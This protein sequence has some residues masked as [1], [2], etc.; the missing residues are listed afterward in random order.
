MTDTTR[1]AP[2]PFRLRMG[3]RLITTA[4]TIVFA[5]AAFAQQDKPNVVLMLAD[6]VGWGDIGAFAGGEL[7]G[8]PTPAIDQLAAEG[9]QLSQ[10]LVEPACTPSRAA[11]LTGRYSTRVG[12]NTVII[13]G[14]PNT[15]QASEVTLAELFKSQGYATAYAGKWHLGLE[16]QS[17]P[18]RQGFD[19]YRVGVIETTDGTLY[20]ESMERSGMPE[21]F[22]KNVVPRIYESDPDGT[23]RAVREYTVEYRAQVEGDIAAASV[24]FIT[25]QADAGAPFFM[26][27]G[28]THSHYPSVVPDEFAGKSPAGPYGDAIMEL[29]YRTGQVLDA[30]EDAGVEDNTIVIWISDNGATPISGP[31]A[32]RGG[33]NG[34][35]RGELGD[36]LE[37]SI[38][39][40]GMIKWPNRIKPGNSFEM[41]SIHDMLP[42]LATIIGAKIPSDR[43]IDG[44]DQSDYFLGETSESNR[45]HLITFIE[46]EVAAVRW[47]HWR[48]YPKEFV[49]SGGNPAR[50]GLGGHRSEMTS[51]PGIYNILN[52]PRE[53]DNLTA[54]NAWVFRPYM[55][56]IGT[57]LKSLETYPIPN[58]VSLTRFDTQ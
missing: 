42:T 12:L 54:S 49:P 45:D 38:R 26:M 9:M 21:E 1:D 16:E 52:D 18:T 10:F 25:R 53:E 46:G 23:L 19:E 14:T 15:L 20:R 44:I 31:P 22:I 5:S 36:A 57:Y 17:W 3:L 51:L 35:F 47:N 37:G 41:V 8:M 29:D 6:N 28:W 40:P 39:V 24:D 4:F 50:P 48:I 55:Q 43:A 7:R 33:S 30:I 11:L 32:Y 2:G 13:G 56:V 34:P 27:I 58:G